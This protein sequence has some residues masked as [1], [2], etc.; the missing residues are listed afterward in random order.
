MAAGRSAITG[1]A[2]LIAIAWAGAPAAA[3]KKHRHEAENAVQAEPSAG[4]ANVVTPVQGQRPQPDAMAD[5]MAGMPGM[6]DEEDRSSMSP[7]GR[8]LDWLGRLHPV[9]VHFPLAFFP[10]AA[11]TA[12]VGRRRPA[13]A[14]PVQFL[15][16]TGGIIAPIAA[17]LGWLDATNADPGALLTVHRWL[18]TA[19]GAAGLTLAIWALKRPDEDRRPARVWALVAITAAL[20]VQG[21]Y[22]GAIV[23]GADHM[24]W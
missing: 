2:L 16:V 14:K 24:N 15:V 10:A 8:L 9:I 12:I 4:Q 17:I 3:H 18:G 1:L 7:I 23:H 22:G 13:F 6:D 11:F 21:W 5:H 20:V 19:I